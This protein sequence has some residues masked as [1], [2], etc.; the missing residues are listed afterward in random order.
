MRIV[1]QLSPE[2]ERVLQEKAARSGQTLDAYLERL[3]EHDA[4][5]AHGTP[6]ASSQSRL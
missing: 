6:A 3:A 4:R 5:A 2:T 1:L